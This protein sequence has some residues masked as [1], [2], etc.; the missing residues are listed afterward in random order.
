MEKE[1]KLRTAIE[2][3]VEENADAKP[4]WETKEFQDKLFET[5]QSFEE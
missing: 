5:Q 4:Y 3:T 1:E 2:K